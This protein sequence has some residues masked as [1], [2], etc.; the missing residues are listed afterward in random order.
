M[1][2]QMVSISQTGGL[3]TTRVLPVLKSTFEHERWSTSGE[4]SLGRRM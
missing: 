4:I 1:A 3:D 2:A